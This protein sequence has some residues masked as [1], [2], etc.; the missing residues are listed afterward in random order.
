MREMFPREH[1]ST[2]CIGGDA[3]P[4]HP[5]LATTAYPELAS[6]F[7]LPEGSSI[8]LAQAG[9][10]VSGGGKGGINTPLLSW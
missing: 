8:V 9:K 6:H 7:L 1:N 4:H 2:A 10:A 3:R 5:R